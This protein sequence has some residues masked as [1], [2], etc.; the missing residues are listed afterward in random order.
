MCYLVLG[1]CYLGQ[2]QDPFSYLRFGSSCVTLQCLEWDLVHGK[3]TDK[4]E[5]G[6]MEVGIR[7]PSKQ[8]VTTYYVPGVI[9]RPVLIQV[10][11]ILPKLSVTK[12]NMIL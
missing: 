12:M 4:G 3:K 9:L 6:E 11:V 8:K 2:I 10:W 5:E 7:I 1:N